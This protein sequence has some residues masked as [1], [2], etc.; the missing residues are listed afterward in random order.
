MSSKT[1]KQAKKDT[2]AKDD[3]PTAHG[4][5]SMSALTSLLEDHRTALSADFKTALTSLEAKLDLVQAAVSDHGP[6]IASMESSADLL[7]ERIHSLEVVCTE[8]TENYAKLKAKTADLEGRSW[9]NNIRIIGL[10]ESVEGPRLT[11][12]F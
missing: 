4:E 8:L 3:V 2:T 9:R 12:F 11:V 6:R 10:P 1:A 7:S 5:V